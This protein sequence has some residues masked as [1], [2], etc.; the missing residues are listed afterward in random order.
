M[1]AFKE[2]QLRASIKLANDTQTNQPTSFSE[3]GTDTVTLSGLRSSLRVQNSGSAAGSQAQFKIFGLTLSLMDQLSTL[4]MVFNIVPK[5]TITVEARSGDGPWAV[6]FSG[7]I[8]AAYGDFNAAPNVPFQ[9]DAL[10]GLG[11][12]VAP[13][14]PVSFSGS[15]DV[16]TI[17]SGFA[18]QMGIGFE[19]NGVN[20]K[21]PAT[22]F[23]GTVWEQMKACAE[24]AHVNA[25]RVDSAGGPVLAIWPIGGNRNTPTVP[26]IAP[27]PAGQEPSAAGHL[28]GY[29]SYTQQGIKVDFVFDPAISRGIL[30]DVESDLKK[31]TGQWAVTKLDL[32]L[33]ALTPKG[34]WMATAYCY[35]PKYPQPLPPQ[36]SS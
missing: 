12:L 27:P 21:L 7:T 2:R 9:I 15:T 24:Y 31:A 36:V 33:D 3:S 19:N 22:Y 23:P 26:K 28:I 32:A 8:F 1:S 29:P 13:A 35:N 20:V 34:E 25:D 16:A 6:V 10:A 14:A 30:V 4:G 5:N 18:R 11:D 17:M